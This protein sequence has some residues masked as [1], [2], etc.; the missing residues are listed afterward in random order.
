MLE[1][2]LTNRSQPIHQVNYINDNTNQLSL[3]PEKSILRHVVKDG[4]DLYF[5]S[6][7]GLTGTSI[8]GLARLLKCHPQT[9]SDQAIKSGVIM[10]AEAYTQ[11]GLQGIKI[12][13]ESEINQILM[14]ILSAKKSSA[15]N[16]KS[17]SEL[18]AKF[19]QAGFRLMVLL[20]VAP[21][22]LA[23]SAIDKITDPVKAQELAEYAE[24]HAKYLDTYFGLTNQ[25]KAHGAVAIHYATVNKFNNDLIGIEKEQRKSMTR[26]QKQRLTLVQLAEEMKLERTEKTTAWNAVNTCRNIGKLALEAIEK[27]M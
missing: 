3:F 4:L 2:L 11:G 25:L 21:E 19:T 10:E 12:I 24:Q 9:V 6:K 16:K 1:R 5:D 13:P 23:A 7:S 18:L 15:K 27:L 26:G 22:Q 14:A 20:E 8:N 17:A